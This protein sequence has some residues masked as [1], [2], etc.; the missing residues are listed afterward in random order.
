[1]LWDS[2]F[3]HLQALDV[4]P[5]ETQS[6]LGMAVDIG[7]TTV[8]AY[9]YDLTTGALLDTQSALNPQRAFGADVI[10]RIG[11]AK[12]SQ[13]LAQQTPG[14]SL[15]ASGYDLRFCPEYRF[16]SRPV[17]PYYH[18]RQYHNAPFVLRLRSLWHCGCA[19]HQRGFAG[20]GASY[21]P[22][23]AWIWVPGRQSLFA[24]VSLLM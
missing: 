24:P 18:C 3:G 23:W 6:L 13:G 1:M 20:M 16:K 21:S 14:D 17:I 4:L 12:E 7:T 22:A 9:Y 19:V 8:V 15:P 2:G 11:A 10:S 5:P